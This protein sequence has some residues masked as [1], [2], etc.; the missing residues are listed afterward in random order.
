MTR[1]RIILGLCALLLWGSSAAWSDPGPGDSPDSWDAYKVLFEQNMFLRNRGRVP[2][3]PQPARPVAP[4]P[5]RRIVLTGIAQ[6]GDEPLA[7]L[8]DVRTGLTIRASI[9]DPLADGRVKEITLDHLVYEKEGEA[10]EVTIGSSLAGSAAT[11]PPVLGEGE[12]EEAPGAAAPAEAS[13]SRGTGSEAAIVELL[14]QRRLKELG[15]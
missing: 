10:V 11:A 2:E 13:P 6:Q 15:E 4:R 14:R 1:R 8:E 5:E 9:G 3:Q 12:Y 7:F